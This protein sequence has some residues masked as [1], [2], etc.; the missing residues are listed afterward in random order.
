MTNVISKKHMGFMLG[1]VIALSLM[2]PALLGFTHNVN[3]A[4]GALTPDQLFGGK[5]TGA[6]FA[7]EAGLGSG[8]LVETISS[9]IRVALGFLGVIAVVII[10]IGGFQWM[11]S[12]GNDDKVKKAKGRIFAGIIG[13]VIVLSAFAIASFVLTQISTATS[14]APAVAT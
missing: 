5:K 6:D 3:A 8:D 2:V 12:G 14:G 11:T 7:S 9:V 10:L 1:A 13:L 4:E